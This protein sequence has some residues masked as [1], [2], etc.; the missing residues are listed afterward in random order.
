MQNSKKVES[1][2]TTWNKN[3][4]LR[5]SLVEELLNNSM[6]WQQLQFPASSKDTDELE[7]VLL[8]AGAQSVTIID[9]E[10]QAIF[11]TEPGATPLWDAVLIYS[12]FEL[13]SDL[14]ALIGRLKEHLKAPSEQELT[15][16]ILQ[17]QEW[18]K[19]W[20]DN[21]HPMQFGKRLWVC[22]HWQPPPHPEA[23]NV[24]LD[25]GLAFGTGT[26][27][28]TAL[29]LEWLEQ[30]DL[31]GKYLIDFGCGSG[32]L[33]I[34]AVLL[35]A[36]QVV[37]I[38]NDPQALVATESNRD[39]NTI[40]KLRLGCYLPDEYPLASP[41]QRADVLIAN[42]LADPLQ[43]LAE[44]FAKLVVA[45][46]FLVLSGILPDQSEALL[47]SYEPWFAMEEPTI[48]DG[49]IR[50]CGIRRYTNKCSNS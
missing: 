5:G 45:D 2:F 14:T 26:H 36:K 27:A 1:I 29:C 12:L 50:L 49:W 20:M 34:A 30:A 16:E 22:P 33:A 17:D 9:A 3:F 31:V 35:G 44:Q 43:Q 10:D 41:P 39:S 32:I 48:K 13:D 40:D 21:F 7:Q 11:Q 19:A 37:A 46:G 23:I 24:V 25:P 42:I 15:V 4:Q 47:Q 18:E 28:T 8:D 38:D 6:A